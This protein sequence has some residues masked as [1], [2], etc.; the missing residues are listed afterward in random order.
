MRIALISI[1]IG[2]TLMACGLIQADDKS[3]EDDIDKEVAAGEAKIIRTSVEAIDD[4]YYENPVA[5][6]ELF[7]GSI[8]EI[9]GQISSISR[10]DDG[11]IRIILYDT[12]AVSGVDCSFADEHE[13]QVLSL[14]RGQS[15]TLRGRG[16]GIGREI[17]PGFHSNDFIARGCSVVSP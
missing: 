11:V 2:I 5:A 15:V 7:K 17:A 4:H 13:D 3:I 16:E 10:D 9:T 14:R 6:D 12:F 8:V 1:L